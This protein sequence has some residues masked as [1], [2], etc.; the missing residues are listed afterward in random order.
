MIYSER[1]ER[2][3]F[4]VGND[5]VTERLKRIPFD[6]QYYSEKWLQEILEY[7]PLLVPAGKVGAQFDNLVCIGREVPVSSGDTTGYIDNLYISSEGRLV[8]VETKLY[9]NQEQRRN[10]ISQI[11]DYAKE[12]TKW[13]CEKLDRVCGDY[14]YKRDG[15]SFRIID[16]LARCGFANFSDEGRI[17]DNINSA[18]AKAD[19]LLM[20]IGDGIRTNVEQIAEFL[21]ENASMA[22]HLALA[23]IE[24]Y[25]HGDGLTLVSG[26]I[27]KTKVIERK[28]YSVSGADADTY[29]IDAGSAPPSKPTVLSRKEFISKFSDL[30][31]YD[32]DAV[33]EFVLEME[34]VSGI[35]VRVTP[36]ELQFRFSVEDGAAYTL[37]AF[38][39]FCDHSDL[40]IMPK[41]LRSFLEKHGHFPMEADGFLDFF[42]TYVDTGR[43]KLPP[44]EHTG[45]YFAVVSE[46]LSHQSEFAQALNSFI[47]QLK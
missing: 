3:A 36:T 8:V 5:G 41:W 33:T 26:L 35:A 29:E 23:E 22:F 24:V 31:G 2:T 15:Q 4:F 7:N 11:L 27:A 34:S 32:P 43:C 37:M 40:Y 17:T 28:I 46:A 45:S 1:T 19:F 47:Q 25:Q 6:T 42:K 9:R 38:T 39:I 12:L 44:Y 14:Y 20:V 16:L 30:G 13:D 18:L 21:N 10:V